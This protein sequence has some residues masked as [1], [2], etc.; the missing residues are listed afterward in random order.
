MKVAVIADKHTVQAFSLAGVKD[1]HVAA[2]LADTGPMEEAFDRFTGNGNFSILFLSEKTA[3]AMAMKL[4][5]FAELKTL[6]PLIITVPDV[7]G[8]EEGEDRIK[9][10]IRRA[11][12]VD[13]QE[14]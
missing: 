5:Y 7:H 1:S 8:E 14:E 4:K 10:L 13:I 11:V 2:D 9:R 6:Y 12:G 3:R